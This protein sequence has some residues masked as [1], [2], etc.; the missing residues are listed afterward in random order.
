FA[1]W[2][3][4]WNSKSDNLKALAKD[5]QLGLDSF[6]F[7]DDNPVECAEVEANCP[8]VL[9]L[10]LP[11]DPG[12]IPQF[13]KHCWAF[14]SLKVTVEDRRRTEMYHENRQRAELRA[15]SMS[16]GDFLAGL[17]LQIEIEPLSTEQ[18]PRVAQLTQRT[19]QF[20]CTTIR[21]T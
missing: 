21:Q 2:R 13:L 19:N 10:Q 6:I 11:E 3:L 1:A 12:Q 5:L 20:N 18:L 14:D 7:V 8:E 17:Q 16:L 4:N 9:V 15:Q